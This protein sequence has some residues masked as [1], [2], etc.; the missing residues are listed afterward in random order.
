MKNLMPPQMPQEMGLQVGPPADDN[1]L[2]D[3]KKQWKGFFQELRDAYADPVR[4]SVLMELGAGLTRD[5][6]P[7]QSAVDSWGRAIEAANA[8]G[9]NAEDRQFAMDQEMEQSGLERDKLENSKTQSRLD[10]QQ[11]LELQKMGISADDKRQERSIE[12]AKDL[13]EMR[14]KG[15]TARYLGGQAAAN[16]RLKQQLAADDAREK[17]Q[18]ELENRRFDLQ[19]QRLNNEWLDQALTREEQAQHLERQSALLAD[20]IERE[21]KQKLAEDEREL[22]KEAAK[23]A[24]NDETGFDQRKFESVFN[25]LLK[26]DG[27][28]RYNPDLGFEEFA[29]RAQAIKDPEQRDQAL[30]VLMN[31]YPHHAEELAPL[32]SSVETEERNRV[33]DAARNVYSQ[34]KVEHREDVQVAA[35]AF[36]G[37]QQELFPVMRKN[38]TPDPAQLQ[39]WADRLETLPVEDL[40]KGL[41]QTVAKMKAWIARKLPQ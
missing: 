9:I 25:A 14:E 18:T 22:I 41:Q 15:D 30:K 37:I 24:T 28:P 11:R 27:N 40:P 36:K 31:A 3:R 2:E 1:E 33:R 4:R 29:N 38:E 19:Q 13:A 32:M 20:K 21:S 35:D 39:D 17:R 12:S 5:L 8:A 7:G 10:R 26:A 23:A 34:E 16:S 6:Q